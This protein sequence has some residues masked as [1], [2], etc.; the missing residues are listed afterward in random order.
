MGRSCPSLR[1][2]PFGGKPKL[3]ILISDK[4]GSA[5]LLLLFLE[6]L[7]L[8]IAYCFPLKNP[9]SRAVPS[10]ERAGRGIEIVTTDD[11]RSTRARRILRRH[12]SRGLRLIGR[13]R[14]EPM[15]GEVVG[16]CRCSLFANT[17]TLRREAD[18]RTG[19]ARDVQA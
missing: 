12:V 9:T 7:G 13:G 17:D 18:A 3:M 19:V 4:N 1:A 15:K 10:W 11:Q 8:R 2:Q 6:P 14:P 16:P 5:I